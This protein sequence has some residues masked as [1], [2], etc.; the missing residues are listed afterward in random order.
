M[1][2]TKTKSAE[3]QSIDLEEAR[4]LT[5]SRHPEL[6]TEGVDRLLKFYQENPAVYDAIRR[7]G[8][9]PKEDLA[10]KLSS[11][12]EK[13]EEVKEA[14]EDCGPDGAIRAQR[15]EEEIGDLLFSIAN[16]ARHLNM[17]P[18]VAL[19]RA[20][21]RFERRFRSIEAQIVSGDA[22]DLEAMDALW[23]QAKR[24][25]SSQA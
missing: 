4:E 22:A 1:E 18:E 10:I 7:T 6:T 21:E 16:L 2:K 14:V 15:V 24:A 19:R 23:E 5:G 20:G 12:N 3:A 13:L 25:E 17:S 8:E 9:H 11:F